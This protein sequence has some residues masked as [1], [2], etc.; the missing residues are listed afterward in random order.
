MIFKN[1]LLIEKLIHSQ[2]VAKLVSNKKVG[3]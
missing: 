2:Y 3:Q 1:T